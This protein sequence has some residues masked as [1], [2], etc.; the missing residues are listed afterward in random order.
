MYEIVLCPDCGLPA[1]LMAVLPSSE[2]DVDEINYRCPICD[3]DFKI[4]VQHKSLDG[5]R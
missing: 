1:K 4:N 3:K 2:S 5:P